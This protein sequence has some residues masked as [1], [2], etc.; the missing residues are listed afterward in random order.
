MAVD[1]TTAGAASGETALAAPKGSQSQAKGQKSIDLEFGVPVFRAAN[2]ILV[3]FKKRLGVFP[4]LFYW[5]FYIYEGG[6]HKWH[7]RN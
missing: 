4:S 7:S 2:A 1:Y 5:V 6:I 3:F